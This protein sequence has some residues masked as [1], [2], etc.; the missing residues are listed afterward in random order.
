MKEIIN[1][2]YIEK[3]LR[4]YEM[5]P[6]KKF[7]QNFLIDPNLAFGIV[8]HLNLPS[9]SK[10]LEIGP[11]LGSLSVHLQTY[12]VSQLVL[13][14]IDHKIAAYLK[15]LFLNDS[16]ISVIEEDVLK[17]NFQEYPYI[18]GN[19]PYNLTTELLTKI[20]LSASSIKRVV[21]MIQ[22][23][24]YERFVTPV[25]N[26]DYGH[27]N[28]LLEYIGKI[29]KIYDAPGSYFYPRPNVDSVVLKI[30]IKED[31]SSE[32]ISKLYRLTHSL[33]LNRRKNILNNLSQFLHSK[34]K[35]QE[36]LTKMGVAVHLRPEQLSIE[37]YIKLA[38]LLTV[39]YNI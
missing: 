35:A 22:K 1:R 19:L 18:I 14:D 30:E 39:L 15:R 37:F 23:E 13:C 24:A 27:L 3:I 7:G 28:I 38:G 8:K 29:E 31:L 20:V 12:P 5:A 33:F 26:K 11:G 36:V 21:I 17:L 9:E 16:Q 6:L 25:G 2:Q 32:F 34:S 4:E 10:V